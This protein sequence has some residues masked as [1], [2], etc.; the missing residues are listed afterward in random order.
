MGRA[1]DHE[2]SAAVPAKTFPPKRFRD[3][4][5]ECDRRGG[6]DTMAEWTAQHGQQTQHGQG[7]QHVTVAY[8]K[9]SVLRMLIERSALYEWRS[10][11]Y[12]DHGP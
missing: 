3:D 2:C 12:R 11:K 1:R 4:V 7:A 6:Q 8:R 9:R 5:E 10:L